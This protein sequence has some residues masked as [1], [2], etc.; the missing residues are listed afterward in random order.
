MSFGTKRLIACILFHTTCDLLWENAVIGNAT[1]IKYRKTHSYSSDWS[2]PASFCDALVRSPD[3]YVVYVRLGAVAHL[4]YRIKAFFRQFRYPIRHDC[5]C[6]KRLVAFLTRTRRGHNHASP[7]PRKPKRTPQKRF[8]KRVR[9]KSLTLWPLLN[10]LA[11]SSSH[12][13]PCKYKCR[14]CFLSGYESKFATMDL[15]DRHLEEMHVK[16]YGTHML[17]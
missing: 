11:V 8:T 17:Y 4:P 14:I 2:N 15:L 10:S 9:Y 6:C 1:H 16:H 12:K 13:V 7:I 3:R 5:E